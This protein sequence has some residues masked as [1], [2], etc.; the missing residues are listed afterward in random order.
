MASEGC[1]TVSKGK[2]IYHNFQTIVG[3]PKSLCM[4]FK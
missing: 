3:A 2:S 1:L 4:D